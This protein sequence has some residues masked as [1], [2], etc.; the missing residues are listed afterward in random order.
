M[1]TS[2]DYIA[3]AEAIFTYLVPL[4]PAAQ[5]ALYI[6]ERGAYY[7]K[8]NPRFDYDRFWLACTGF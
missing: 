7:K 1:A 6:A 4:L 2:K 5:L 3:E 8:D